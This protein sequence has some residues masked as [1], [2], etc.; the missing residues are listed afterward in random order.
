MI[1]RFSKRNVEES[2]CLMTFPPVKNRPFYIINIS[3]QNQPVFRLDFPLIL[4]GAFS[5]FHNPMLL[6]TGKEDRV[7]NRK[8]V[9]KQP[10]SKSCMVCG[11]KNPFGLKTSFYELE[12]NELVG[13]FKPAES[14]QS[15]PGRLHGGVSTAILDETVG[16]AV[17]CGKT[18]MVWGVTVEFTTQFKKPVPIGVELKVVGRIVSE[19]S[20]T[21]EGTGEILLPDGTVAVT[22]TGR[23]LKLALNRIADFDAEEQEWKV[24]ASG[25]D[26]AIIV[27]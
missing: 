15:Y 16:R 25:Q 7:L 8:V 17:N 19:T 6:K 1:D 26:P 5:T 24:I 14:H 22:G 2:A 11:L 13:L 9:R 27:Y 12:G 23:Y 3:G 21:F 10:N 18:E 4:R 20:R